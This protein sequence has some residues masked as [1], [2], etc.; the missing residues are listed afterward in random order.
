MFNHSFKS[1][2][3]K[4]FIVCILV[5]AMLLTASMPI[6]AMGENEQPESNTEKITEV[7][8]EAAD[9]MEAAETVSADN[10]NKSNP[11]SEQTVQATESSEPVVSEPDQIEPAADTGSL[12]NEEGVRYALVPADYTKVTFDHNFDSS[13]LPTT[14]GNGVNEWQIIRGGYKGRYTTGQDVSDSF[15]KNANV[16]YS[17][18]NAV[19]MTKNVIS[20]DTEN[21]FH[22][23]L[24]VEPQVSWEEILQL[25]TIIVSHNNRPLSPPAYPAGGGKSETF[26]SVKTGNYQTPI[27]FVYYANSNGKKIILAKIVMYATSNSVPNGGIGIGNPLLSGSG[28]FYAHNNFDLDKGTATAEIDIST[29]YEKYEF[30]TKKVQVNNVQDQVND[31]M[32]V[33]EDSFNFDGGSCSLGGNVINWTMPTKDLGLLPYKQGTDG[34]I[35]PVGVKRTLSNGKVTYYRQEAYQLSYKFSLDV[36]NENFTSATSKNSAN[37]ISAE[38]AVQTNKSPDDASDKEKG[39]KVTYTTNGQTGTGDFKSPYIKGLLYD[40]EFQKVVEGSKVPLAGVTFTIERQ[41]GGSTYS[42]QIVYTDTKVTGEDGW[43]KFHNLPWGTYTIKEISYK[44]GDEFQTN[45][46]NTGDLPKE[47]GT[48]QIGELINPTALTENHSSGHSGDTSSDIKNR[49]FVFQNGTVENTPNRARITIVKNVNSYDSIPE[50]L[51]SQKYTV[52]VKSTGNMKIYE[53]PGIQDDKLD[54]LNRQ[55]QLGHQETATYDLIVPKNGGTI[56]L[57]EVIPESIKNKVVFDSATVTANTGSTDLGSVTE[58]EQGCEVTVLPGNDLTVTITNTP[59]GTVKIKKVIDNYQKELAEDAFIIQA[60]SADDNGTSVN[61]EAVLKHDESSGTITI[62]KTT[63]LNINEI[64][65]K[66]YSLSEITISGGGML[67]GNQV[68]VNPGENVTVTVHNTYS[69]KPFFHVA[70][71]IKNQFKWK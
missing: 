20:T 14:P 66:E 60:K 39:G 45:Y 70:D 22:M 57:Q 63:T 53:K 36:Q 44:D 47:L 13:V 17:N 7:Q 12:E 42:E 32:K 4:C 5:M 65:P 8:A 40:L 10:Q 35:T 1:K 3:K 69:G 34:K 61:T 67:N 24:N 25:N 23:Y 30:S 59:V 26:S 55:Q 6:N 54:S 51:K 41:A 50:A 9:D 27:N 62:K 71:A 56:N 11:P 29:L 38:Y 64:V 58:K 15:D 2:Y 68:T 21:E 43:I 52:N 49:L 28:S 19:R 48:V 37:N 46:L 31:L 18:D 33:Y 16:S